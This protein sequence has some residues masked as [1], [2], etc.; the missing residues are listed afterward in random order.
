M[1]VMSGNPT[2]EPMHYGEVFATWSYL[3]ATKGMVAGYQTMLNHA[4]DQN[5][6]EFIEDVIKTGKQEEEQIE[7]L[8]KDNGV[9]LPPTPPERPVA[10]LESIPIGARFNDPEIAT[11]IARDLT[12]GMVACSQA[13]GQSIREDI[14]MMYGQFHM[15]KAQAGVTLLRMQKEKGWLVPPPLHIQEPVGAH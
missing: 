7:R 2:D 1:G 10:N 13:M 4:G 11:S 6:R 14:G 15:K 12:T 9:G 3:G 5:L 8:L